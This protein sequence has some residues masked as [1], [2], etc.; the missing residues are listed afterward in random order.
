MILKSPHPLISNKESDDLKSSITHDTQNKSLISKGSSNN[1]KST[2]KK[3]KFSKP[4]KISNKI[5]P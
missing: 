3:L 1:K 2:K 4:K 5:K